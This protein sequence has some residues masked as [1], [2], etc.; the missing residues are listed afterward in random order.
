MWKE[1]K[2][3]LL[4]LPFLMLA[5]AALAMF[6]GLPMHE[7]EQGSAVVEVHPVVTVGCGPIITLGLW[8]LLFGER[9]A[10]RHPAS[11][12]FT[13]LGLVLV[14]LGF[15]GGGLLYWWLEVQLGALGY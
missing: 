12:Q 4:A 11:R 3:R 9:L 1:V 8:Q 10:W 2:A 14:L 13:R 15:A 6:V 5:F 7:A